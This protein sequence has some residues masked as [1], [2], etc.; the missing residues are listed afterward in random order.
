ML[1]SSLFR[2]SNSSVGNAKLEKHFF[3]LLRQIG[4]P[5]AEGITSEVRD[6][7]NGVEAYLSESTDGLVLKLDKAEKL[8]KKDGQVL[9]DNLQTILDEMRI[10]EDTLSLRT[11]SEFIRSFS[12]RSNCLPKSLF[13]VVQSRKATG[14][15]PLAG[16]RFWD[17]YQ[18]KL[19]KEKVAIKV[20][21]VSHEDLHSKQLKEVCS[22]LFI[23]VDLTKTKPQEFQHVALRL[24]HLNH[25]NLLP[26]L[27]V[28]QETFSN[29]ICFIY[30]WIESGSVIEFLDARKNATEA[31][32]LD[33]V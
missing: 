13:V 14:D 22:C 4:Y 19:G 11:I 12:S 5:G 6:V 26:L 30:P 25:A 9:L 33:I 7:A 29:R 18:G 28:D 32:K 8:A 31:E 24:R 21:R 1:A 3:D 27:G 20:L 15:A 23:V 2:T 16:G 10:K 17:V